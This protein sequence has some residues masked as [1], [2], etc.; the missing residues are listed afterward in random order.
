VLHEDFDTEWCNGVGVLQDPLPVTATNDLEPTSTSFRVA[1]AGIHGFSGAGFIGNATPFTQASWQGL[2]SGRVAYVMLTGENA[3][4]EGGRFVE[5]KPEIIRISAITAE[6]TNTD[7][8]EFQNYP[9][10]LRFTIDTT[11]PNGGRA[12]FE[13][14]PSIP[15]F[16]KATFSGGK[17]ALVCDVT[18]LVDWCQKQLQR[19][20]YGAP[21]LEVWTNL[22]KIAVRVGELVNIVEDDVYLN[23]GKDGADSESKFEAVSKEIRALDDSPGI[24]WELRLVKDDLTPATVPAV[25]D[26]SGYVP[27]LKP[28]ASN[29]VIVRST[30]DFVVTST[31]DFVHVR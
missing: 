25:N 15:D 19:L 8:N 11:A 28:T 6:G 1:F 23:Y 27:D 12:Q 16:W 5:G 13:S 7:P 21:L 9:Q 30:S 18:M 14:T 26:D 31:P 22:S 29:F 10:F 2:G 4:V 17:P 3:R 20:A 24:R